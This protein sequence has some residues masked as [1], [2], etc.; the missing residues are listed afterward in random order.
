MQNLSLVHNDNYSLRKRRLVAEGIV[1]IW[2][3]SPG[4]ITLIDCCQI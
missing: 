4:K 1:A 3:I 2:H